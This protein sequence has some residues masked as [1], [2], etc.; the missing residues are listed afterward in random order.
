MKI[1]IVGSGGQLG[2]EFQKFLKGQENVYAFS[3]QE[4]DVTDAEEV[5]ATLHSIEPDVVVNCAAYTRVDQAEREKDLCHRINVLGARNVAWAAYRI[6]AKVVYFSTDYVFDGEHAIPYTELDEPCPL[7]VYGWSK[8]WGEYFTRSCNPNHL[9]VRTSWL[10]GE[11]GHNFVK[12][13]VRLA[14]EKGKLKVVDDQHGVPTWTKDLVQQTFEL[15]VRDRVGLY[16]CASLGQTS[17]FHVSQIIIQVLG[18]SAEVFPIST[19]EYGALAR[20]PKYSVLSN[21][22]LELEG[23]N[24]MRF[25]EEAL[26]E[27][28]TLFRKEFLR[29]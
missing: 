18:L 11:M 4:L 9:V 19:E 14:R 13:V 17:W 7:S 20:R 24:H 3:R 27:F 10:Y 29:E 6:R 16:H 21:Y 12:T 1:V 28:L 15:L 5:F 23:L 2:N 26:R 22:F 8:L 25:W